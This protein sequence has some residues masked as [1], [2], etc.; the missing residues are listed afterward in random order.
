MPKNPVLRGFLALLGLCLLTFPA[1]AQPVPYPQRIVTLVTHSSPG[2][3]T[4]VYL[5]EL[6]KY[7]QRY[8]DAK[9]IVE[10][11]EGGS[12]AKAMSRV[13]SAKPDGSVIYAAT[14]TYVLISL[15]S[16]PART[17]RDLEPVV[18]LFTDSEMIYVRTD[19]PYK[20]L[21][22]VLD[23]AKTKRGLWGVSNP[24]SQDRQSAELLR[25]AANVNASVITH[26]GGADAMINV[27]NGTLDMA[28]GEMAE[29]RAQLEGRK[30]RLLATFDAERLAAYPAV[31]TVKELGY[32]VVLT[33]FRGFA[34][35]KG[36]P[37]A[38]VKIWEEAAQKIIADPEYKK[39]YFVENMVPH[40]LPHDQYQTFIT[41]FA[42]DTGTFLKSTGVIH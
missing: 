31:P 7:L 15:L 18:N 4:D 38:I 34:A 25:R 22:D 24:A 39:L 1:A 36:L 23:R 6:T 28:L 35:P 9:F 20:T 13:A 27:L 33:K 40:Y 12:G 37:P 41:Q 2:A 8:I 29:I 5:R 19:S 26:N 21:Q 11:D 3:T 17:Y 42:A 16:S 10:N 14:P 30:I 32:D